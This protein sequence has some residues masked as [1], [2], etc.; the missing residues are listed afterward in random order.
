[1][2]WHLQGW[3]DEGQGTFPLHEETLRPE[4]RPPGATWLLERGAGWGAPAETGPAQGPAAGLRM[5][6]RSGRTRPGRVG[7][8]SCAQD[9]RGHLLGTLPT[10]LPRPLLA[11]LRVGA[12]QLR[13][14][15]P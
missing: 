11:A 9:A 6:S 2:G 7:S 13:G 1:M 10:G 5:P 12:A 3:W 8:A 15:S 4:L 14:L